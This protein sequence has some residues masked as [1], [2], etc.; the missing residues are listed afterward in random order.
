[1]K[2]C[3]V[4]LCLLSELALVSPVLAQ[5][6]SDPLVRPPV[7]GETGLVSLTEGEVRKI[8]KAAAKLTIKHGV[9]K[10]LD[11][12]GMTMVFQ[13]KDT[14]LLDKVVVGEKIRFRVESENGRLVVT[15]IEAAN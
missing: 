14:A 1:M 10:H 11:M 4:L 7:S 3:A 2:R 5:S 13:I 9:I 15:S 6:A 8:D 12:P